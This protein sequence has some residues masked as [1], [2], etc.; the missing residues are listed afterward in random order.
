MTGIATD[1]KI[2]EI[3]NFCE[4]RGFCLIISAYV[5]ILIMKIVLCY[6]F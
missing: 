6:F 1:W 4:V 5:L 2:I 3:V